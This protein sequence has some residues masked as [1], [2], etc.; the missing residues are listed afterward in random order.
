MAMR[1]FVCWLIGLV[2]LSAAC[3]GIAPDSP[4]TLAA[5]QSPPT[6]TSTMLPPAV[7]TPVGPASLPSEASPTPVLTLTLPVSPSPDPGLQETSPQPSPPVFRAELISPENAAGLVQIKEMRFSSWEL[8]TAIA[9]SP[10]GR[11]LAASAGE[12]I[13]FYDVTTWEGLKTIRVGAFTHGLAFSPDGV[14]L[15]G[16]SRDGFVRIWK[17]TELQDRS[18]ETTKPHIVLDAHRKGANCLVFSPDG[19]LLVSGGNDAVARVWSLPDGEKV[20][21]IVGGTFAIPS[22]AFTPDGASL[23]MVNGE[24]VRLRDITSGRIVGTVLVSGVSFYS[25]AISPDGHILAAGDNNN[26][27]RLWDPALAYRTGQESYPTAVDLIGHAGKPGSYQALIWK[28]VF[29]PDGNLLASA[30]GDAT[31]R[32][33]DPVNAQ[34]LATLY[35]HAAGVTSVVFSPDGRSLAS[36]GLDATLRIWGL[37]Q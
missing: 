3:K 28:L 29:S 7:T 25:V 5:S 21:E 11:F 17:T 6:V 14:W 8:V 30:G 27:V 19:R 15:A 20:N 9:W 33:W 23:A 34:L 24:V 36:G 2:F 4:S 1:R 35:G 16:A 22:I 10:D 37:G 12:D 32:L 18:S 26:L 31:V 13:H